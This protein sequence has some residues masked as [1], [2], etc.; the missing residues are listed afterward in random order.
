MTDKPEYL[1][2]AWYAA[3]LSSEVDE[4]ELFRRKI[5]GK[6]VLIYRGEDGKPIGMHDRCPHR[7]APLSQ[8]HRDGDNVV[9]PYHGLAFNGAGNCVHNPHGRGTLP[10]GQVVGTFPLV[11][12]HGFIWIWMAE[13]APDYDLVPDYAPLDE[14]PATGIGH[15]YMQMPVNYRMILDN[16]MDLSHVDHVHGEIITTRG[17]LTPLIPKV[18]EEDT[19]ISAR[20]EWVQ[21]PPILILAPFLARPED[22]ADHYV[23][24]NWSAPAN[25]QLSIGA[26][27]DGAGFDQA[28]MQ[29]D[30]HTCTPEDEFSTHYFFATR[31]NHNEDDAEYNAFKIKAM[32]DAFITEDGPIILACQEEMGE[33]DFFDMNPMLLSNDL[34]PVKVRRRIRDLIKREQDAG[35][36]A[37]AAE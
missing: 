29:Y 6:G 10:K 24:V 34:A 27:Q 25:I 4:T 30:L 18:V 20:W 12:K 17:Q 15:T 22:P 3:A 31:R 14:G 36:L 19:A 1:M 21:Q 33:D 32:H 5:M 9:C 16:V 37:E 35:Q 8:G 7:F 13:E 11:E 23:Q 26:V 2:Q 28:V